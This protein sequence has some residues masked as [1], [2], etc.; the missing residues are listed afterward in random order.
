MVYFFSHLENVSSLFR[1]AQ[2]HR[3]LFLNFFR[4]NYEETDDRIVKTVKDEFSDVASE[5]ALHPLDENE[6][7]TLISNLLN[8][9]GLPQSLKDQITGRAGGN[10]FFIEEVVRSLIDVSRRALRLTGMARY[11]AQSPSQQARISSSSSF[12]RTMTGREESFE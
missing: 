11:A 10:P 3:I 9:K 1:L 2:G 4:P 5:I 12:P 6:S 8:I 7:S